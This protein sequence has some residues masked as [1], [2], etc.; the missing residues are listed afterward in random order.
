MRIAGLVLSAALA[1]L[2]C[3]GPAGPDGF[4]GTVGPGGPTGD[5]GPAGPPGQTGD[6]GAPGRNAYLV[7]PGLDFDIQSAA[8]DAKGVATVRFRITDAGGLPLDRQGLYTEGAVTAH[9]VLAWLDQTASGQALAYTA[10]TTTIE[11][12]PITSMSAV[13]AA[14]D[15]GGP[16]SDVDPEQGVYEYTFGAPI[17][18]AAAARTHT[19]GVWASRDFQ[20]ATYVANALH[21]FLP[22]GGAVTVQREVV[23]T[24]ACNGC[25]DPLS[26]HG[27]ERRDARLCVLCHSPQTT[28][29]DTGNTV[30]FGVMVHKIHRGASLP[31]VAA[32]AP[33]QIIGDMEQVNDYST[34]AFPQDIGRCVA[35]HQ[36]K[37]ADNWKNLPSRTACGSCH[38]RTSFAPPPVATGFTQHKGG[39]QADDTKCTVCHPPVAG[40]AGVATVHLPPD[41]D[42]AS[43]EL[44]LSIKSVV[45]TAPG[46]MPEIVFTAQLDGMPLDLLASPLPLLAVTV[47]GP[48]TDYASFWQQTIQGTGAAG[49]LKLE[50]SVGTY[51]YVFASPM[52][53]SATGT[54]G[55]ALEGYVQPGGPTGPRFGALNPIA[56]AA[57]TDAAP[58]PRRKVVDGG[59]CD[60]CHFELEA[61]G[62]IRREVQYC[63]FCHNP[64]ADDSQRVARFEVPSTTAQSVD[65]KVLVHKIHMGDALTRQPYVIGGFP[66]PTASNPGGTPLDFGAVRYPGDRK[67]CPTCHAGATYALPLGAAV[68]PSLSEELA[69]TDP[70]PNPQSYCQTRVVVAKTYTP[71]TTAVCTA[72]HD[73]PYVLAHA[74]TNTASNGVEGCAACHGPK[75]QWDV[76]RVHAPSP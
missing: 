70:A 64:N 72:C 53:A 6:A 23:T 30:D 54:Y 10:Y 27:G 26:A 63:A 20:G 76:Q 14:A 24:A 48:T 58:V 74:Q 71:P 34:V 44:T 50:G 52:P 69:C 35:C 75:A 55:F 62:G 32:G 29:A 60:S 15:Q 73:A 12:S 49:S 19:V 22:G 13:Q 33:Y 5:A 16:F 31:S 1:L 68:L 2:G 61:H 42:P 56:F 21:D 41:T 3:E 39:P 7:G 38:D 40:L 8:V 37:Q 9:F 18:V 57:V 65:F 43:P 17:A 67:S 11:K 46:S 59:Q 47:A 28:D 51:R 4:P 25:H 45:S 36:G 66:A